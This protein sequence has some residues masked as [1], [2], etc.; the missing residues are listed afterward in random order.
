MTRKAS[1]FLTCSADLLYPAA[2][3]AAV[4]VLERLG[5]EVSFPEAQTCCGQPFVNT[6]DM[7]GAKNQALHFAETFRDAEFI[8]ACSASCV[9]T[10]RNRY[11]TLFHPDS[12]EMRIIEA[13]AA[14]TMEFTEYLS[15]VL[16]LDHL[17]PHPSP[18]RT[19][20]HSSCR[21]LRGLGLKGVAEGYL[22]DMLGEF[23]VSLPDA[24]TCCGFGGTFS[25]KFP[26]I[27]AKLMKDKLAAIK[28]TGA[29]RVASLDL[30]CLTH[31]SC[32]AAR[33]GPR[34][35]RFLHLAEVMAEALRNGGER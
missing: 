14:R 27:S 8:V 34:E 7:E 20:Y 23:F 19:T 11:P 28:S 6:G 26:E 3:R 24:E 12:E 22:S 1:L 33:G 30:A 16:R 13:A 10:V 21:T 5:V 35:V 15:D 31:L 17:P 25:V 32:G 18:V 29:E 4:E 9:D 2:A